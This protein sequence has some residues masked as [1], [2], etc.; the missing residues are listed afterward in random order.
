[1]K[2]PLE[3]LLDARLALQSSLLQG[4]APETS[5]CPKLDGKRHRTE[6]GD[7]GAASTTKAF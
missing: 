2:D 1:M 7:R 4:G 3:D 6:E 5:P